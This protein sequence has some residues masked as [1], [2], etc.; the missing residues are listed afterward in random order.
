MD[1][2][3]IL[4]DHADIQRVIRR[5]AV[6]IWEHVQEEDPPV[7]IGLNTKGYRM[8]SLLSKHLTERSGMDFDVHEFVVK[9]TPSNQ[10]LPDC[11]DRHVILVDDV[12]FSGRTMFDAIS[13]ICRAYE[14]KRIQTLLLLDRGHRRY[15]IKADIVGRSTPTKVGE[16]IE[17]MLKDKDL[18]KVVLFKNQ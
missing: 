7:I 8:G 5:M 6:Q 4:M 11:S 1:K 3:I 15:P 12:I 2:Q 16:H 14:P 13:T 10:Q 17:V 18:Q 9:D